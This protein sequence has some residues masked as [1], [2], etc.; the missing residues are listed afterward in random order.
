[1]KIND[2]VSSAIETVKLYM[3]DIAESDR[4][5]AV[6][7][8]QLQEEIETTNEF[9]TVQELDEK[10]KYAKQQLKSALMSN[11]TYNN[12][13]EEKAQLQEKKKDQKQILSDHL[14]AYFQLSGGERQIEVSADGDAR[15]VI[16]SG[17]LGKE[18]KFQTNLFQGEN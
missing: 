15:E 3:A 5:L 14:V 8:E 17:K 11:S 2:D 7:K 10:F 16:V 4:K 1:M 18:Q 12:L 6:L 13:A 9:E